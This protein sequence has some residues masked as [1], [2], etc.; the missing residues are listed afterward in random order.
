MGNQPIVPSTVLDSLKLLFAKKENVSW[1]S[2]SLLILKLT[3]SNI[4]MTI[5]LRGN[6]VDSSVIAKVNDQI[7]YC[8]PFVP[9]PHKL[10]LTEGVA[11]LLSNELYELFGLIRTFESF[12]PENDCYQEHDFGCI[13]MGD[14]NYFFKFDYFDENYT[15]FQENG[16]RVLTIMLSYEY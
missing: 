12:K 9:H 4:L 8:I 11:L 14:Q 10:V 13:N 1:V 15:Y 16:N 6:T 2:K 7:R 3:A 5:F